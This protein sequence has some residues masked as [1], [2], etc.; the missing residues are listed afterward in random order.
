MEVDGVVLSFGEDDVGLWVLL[1]VFGG[2]ELLELG[3][4][5]EFLSTIK[6]FDEFEFAGFCF[7]VAGA[8]SFF[9]LGFVVEIAT[10]PCQD[11]F[12]KVCIGVD[13]MTA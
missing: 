12:V 8:L 10:E 3:E 7:A 13:E 9:V 11:I 4:A 1:K 6:T 2:G 5:V